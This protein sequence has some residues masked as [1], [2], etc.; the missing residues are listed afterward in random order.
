M[1]P[2]NPSVS[3]AELQVLK[4]LWEHGPATVRELHAALR[5]Q[6]QNWAYTTVQTLL[7]R[8]QAK[9]C[10]RSDKGGPAHVFEATVSRDGLLQR[11]L[12]ELADQLC[13]G[14]ATPLLLALVEGNRFT[15]AEI[16]QFRRLLDELEGKPDR[17]TR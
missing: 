13:E 3:D 14:T 10:A 5:R 8:L 1:P 12:D 11:R 16:A 9:R 15:P 17:R 7:L 6:G 2:L 4:A